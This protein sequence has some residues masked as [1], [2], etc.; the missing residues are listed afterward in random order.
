MNTKDIINRLAVWIDM[1]KQTAANDERF[2]LGNASYFPETKNSTVCIVG[3]WSSGFSSE[4]NDLMCISD[5]DSAK[6][7][8]VKIVKRPANLFWQDFDKLEL[9]APT[10]EIEDTQIALEW[11]DDSEAVALFFMSE[12]ERITKDYRGV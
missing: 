12:W 11:E 1:L 7:M 4:Y 8:C 9:P 5:S 10:G 6:C 2:V 3:G